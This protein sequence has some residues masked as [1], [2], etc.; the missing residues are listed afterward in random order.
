MVVFLN[1]GFGTTTLVFLLSFG[2]LFNAIRMAAT[3]GVSIHTRSFRGIGLAGG[4][5]IIAI[6]LLVIFYPGIGV[7][8]IILLLAS[9]LIIQGLG[10]IAQVAHRGHPRWLRV[11]AVTVGVLT[12]L[13][14]GTTLAFPDL[15]QISLVA[16]LT[17]VV[18]VTGLEGLIAGIRPNNKRQQTILKLLIFALFYGFLI[19]NWIDLFAT[20]APAYHV[21]LILTYMA[22]FGVLLVFQGWKDWQ[23]ALSLGLLVS[24]VND[25][26][27]FFT[28]DLLFGFHVQLLPWLA[29]QLGLL[30]NKVLFIFQGGIVNFPV[31]SILMGLSIYGRLAVVIA[32]LYHWWRFPSKRKI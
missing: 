14:A 26:G 25:T 23:L 12:L 7:S 5:V 18:L 20:N 11:S 13:L 30:G 4:A 32:I 17:L 21:W 16:L 10:R 27:Y 8:T 2:L 22:P 28:G 29:G 6:V 24:L 9:G 15:T 31:T 19:V 3:G 1:P